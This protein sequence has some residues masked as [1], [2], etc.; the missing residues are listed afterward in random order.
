MNRNPIFGKK[1]VADTIARSSSGGEQ[2]AE[3]A[4]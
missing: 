2:L 3:A 4:E 1:M